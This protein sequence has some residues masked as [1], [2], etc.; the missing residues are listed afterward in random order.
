MH[1]RFNNVDCPAGALGVTVPWQLSKKTIINN[2][3][4]CGKRG[5]TDETGSGAEAVSAHLCFVL[6]KKLESCWFCCANLLCLLSL[7]SS[8]AVNISV[9]GS[10]GVNQSTRRTN[11]AVCSPSRKSFSLG[12]GSRLL[13]KSVL[14]TPRPAVRVSSTRVL[15][16]F[17]PRRGSYA[18]FQTARNFRL[19]NLFFSPHSF[20]C[21]LTMSAQTY[22]ATTT[23][24]SFSRST[25]KNLTNS[26]RLTIKSGLKHQ[27]TGCFW[28]WQMAC[29]SAETRLKFREKLAEHLCLRPGASH[30]N[31]ALYRSIIYGPLIK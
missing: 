17:Y 1:D 18:A 28:C 6:S 25:N 19:H 27:F 26:V 5:K 13:E 12:G 30:I 16:W 23:F 24:L 14:Q 29:I 2:N 8:R 15:L 3:N 20:Y 11:S 21:L 4:V 7:S 22:I 10:H 31:L 9:S